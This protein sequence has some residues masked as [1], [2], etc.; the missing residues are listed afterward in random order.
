MLDALGCVIF[1][2][3]TARGACDANHSATPPAHITSQTSLYDHITPVLI[4]LHSLPAQYFVHTYKRN[5]KDS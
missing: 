4:G 1:Q 5:M 3:I 2:G